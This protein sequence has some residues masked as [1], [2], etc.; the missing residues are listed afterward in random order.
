MA[1]PRSSVSPVDASRTHID[2]G[3]SPSSHST[4]PPSTAPLSIEHPEEIAHPLDPADSNALVRL[5]SADGDASREERID[6]ILG[7]SDTPLQIPLPLSI[8]SRIPLEIFEGVIDE[9]SSGTLPA[10]ALVCAVW[11]PRAMRNLYHTIYLFERSRFEALAKSMRTFP[12]VRG[13]LSMTRSLYVWHVGYLPTP[14][15]SC[16]R[17]YTDQFLHAVPLTFGRAMSGLQSLELDGPVAPYLIPKFTLALSYFKAL[18]SLRLYIRLNNVAEQMRIIAASPHLTDLG[19]PFT[20]DHPEHR[21]S[22]PKL[23]PDCSLGIRLRSLSIACSVSATLLID[24][25]VDSGFVGSLQTLDIM[26]SSGFSEMAEQVDRVLGAARLSLVSYWEQ[27]AFYATDMGL[28]TRSHGNLMHNTN[29]RSLR[30]E[31]LMA[32]PGK[33]SDGLLRMVDDFVELLATIRGYRLEHISIRLICDLAGDTTNKLRAA[34]EMLSLKDLHDIMRRPY[35][36]TLKAVEVNIVPSNSHLKG[37]NPYSGSVGKARADIL[38]Y[39]LLDVIRG[40]L[41]PWSDR[42]ILDLTPLTSVARST[43]QGPDPFESPRFLSR[44]GEPALED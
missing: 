22:T 18:N 39:G 28:K 26:R 8:S 16:K 38:A 4:P 1:Q 37:V 10:A 13:W 30:F 5:P 35:F 17:Q 12:R 41:Q 19:L 36:G 6:R 42:G 11:Y 2:E 29:L 43:M 40:L 23:R 14:N 15:P 9:M 7:G 3:T 33:W 20:M 24:W 44:K 34:F 32:Y 21:I 27:S 25:L 31:P